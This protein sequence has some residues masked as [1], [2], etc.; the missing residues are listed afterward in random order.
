MSIVAVT[1]SSCLS[2]TRSEAA[3]ASETGR[4]QGVEMAT[5]AFST[6]DGRGVTGGGREKTQKELLSTGVHEYIYIM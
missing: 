6:Y 1:V 5:A 2:R 3:D 4:G